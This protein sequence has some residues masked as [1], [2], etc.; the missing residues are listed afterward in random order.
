MKNLYPSQW[1]RSLII[2]LVALLLIIICLLTAAAAKAQTAANWNFNGTTA[3]TPGAHLTSSSTSF[4]SSIV[5]YAFNGTT[6]FYGQDGWPTGALNPHA[7]LEF[8]VGASTGYYAVLNSVT[9]TIRR[10]NTGSP[11]GAGPNSWSL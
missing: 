9:M 10:S 4:G 11:A 8:T 6:E 5:S 2:P 1:N 7:Y 3:G